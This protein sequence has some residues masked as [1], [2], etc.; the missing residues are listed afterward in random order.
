MPEESRED[1][2]SEEPSHEVT[3]SDDFDA[4][5]ISIPFP[6]QD[7]HVYSNEP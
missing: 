4:E 1:N 6:Q 3:Y 2:F 7:I 5:G